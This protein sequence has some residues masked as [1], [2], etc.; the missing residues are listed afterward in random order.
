[1]RSRQRWLEVFGW[2]GTEGYIAA[3]PLVKMYTI[4]MLIL[5]NSCYTHYF[6]P[7]CSYMSG[8]ARLPTCAVYRIG[9]VLFATGD[10]QVKSKNA[11]P[12]R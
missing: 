9:A 3:A 8:Q 10:T 7:L 1:M 2:V 4:V 5:C 12:E 11:D 6:T